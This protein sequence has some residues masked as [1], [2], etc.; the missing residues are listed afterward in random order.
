[1][2]SQ[3]RMR[4]G[5]GPTPAR[6]E[7]IGQV[8]STGTVARPAEVRPLRPSKVPAEKPSLLWRLIFVFLGFGIAM[9]GW[10]LVMSVVL[11]FIGLPLLIFGA[12]LMQAQKS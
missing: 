3:E 5:T 4:T 8:Q 2:I 11:S 1:M 12:A 9:L 10:A 6:L 7:P